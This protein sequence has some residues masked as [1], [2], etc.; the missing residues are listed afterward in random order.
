M[1][2]AGIH[3]RTALAAVLRAGAACATV[4][5]TAACRR[6]APLPAGCTAVGVAGLVPGMTAGETS[7]FLEHNGLASLQGYC[8]QVGGDDTV[9]VDPHWYPAMIGLVPGR[10]SATLLPLDAPLRAANFDPQFLQPA[11]RDT[12]VHNGQRFAVALGWMPL[13]IWANGRLLQGLQVAPPPQAPTLAQLLQYCARV[14]Q[15]LVGS[16]LYSDKARAAVQVLAQEDLRAIFPSLLAAFIQGNGGNVSQLPAPTQA[17]DLPGLHSLAELLAYAG[18]NKPWSSGAAVLTMASGLPSGFAGNHVSYFPRLQQPVLPVQVY[19]VGCSATAKA[20]VAGVA[21]WSARLAQ[22]TPQRSLSVTARLNPTA[23][24]LAGFAGW[25]PQGIPAA[26]L[27]EVPNG[28]NASWE[29]GVFDDPLWDAAL[30][31][32]WQKVASSSEPQLIAAA[33]GGA[34]AAGVRASRARTA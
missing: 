23:R 19:G 21:L 3:R 24:A 22:P 9:M 18:G 32:T 33:L 27:T 25:V 7:A 15:A 5:L 31:T 29:W 30:S 2:A 11:F 12:F 26:P 13:A 8:F 28:W 20:R 4:S 34:I 16:G 6:S 10:A 1:S 14:R 17:A